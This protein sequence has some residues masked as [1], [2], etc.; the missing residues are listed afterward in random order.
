M[1]EG[2][3]ARTAKYFSD[4]AF[5]TNGALWNGMYYGFQPTYLV[6]ADL[7]PADDANIAAQPDVDALPFDLS[8]TVGGGNVQAARNA[9]EAALIPAQSV[10]GQMTWLQVARLVG[11][12]FQFMQRVYAITGPQLMLDSSAKLNAQWSSVPADP[13]QNAI[14][15]AAD[16]F[17]YDSSFIRSN[18]Q[19]R[20]II[21]NFG[22]Q[23][24]SQPF[25]LGAF[26]F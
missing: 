6:A 10:N 18:T 24:G 21:D 7:L 5:N 26:V 11:G 12:M 15:A 20:T 14:I 1:Q 2:E 13:W 17:G 25:Y 19:V 9:L 3:Q 8:P 4:R 22:S 23:W 16:S